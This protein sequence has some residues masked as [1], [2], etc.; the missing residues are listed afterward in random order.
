M[1][2]T[3]GTCPKTTG[4]GMHLCHDCTQ[5]LAHH[6]A[7]LTATIAELR[8]TMARQDTGTPS[9]GS[10]S[11]TPQPAINL[12]ALEAYEQLRE[13]TV[14]WAVALQGRAFYW[15][16]VTED[17]GT[18]LHQN[19]D[20]V[21][22][23]DWAPDLARELAAA[24]KQAVQ[25]TDRAADKISLGRCQTITEG[26]RC[27]DTVTAIQGHT[28]GRCRTCGTTVDVH[29]HQQWLI[30]EA[31]HVQAPLPAILRALKH[32]GHLNIP[33]TRAENW[34]ARGKLAPVRDKLYTPAAVMEAHK[35]SRAGKREAQAA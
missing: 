17:A 32:S 33:I 9:V 3:C 14:G 19:L 31:W 35:N 12:D 21:R 2:Q 15:L 27:P 20:L 5:T 10:G 6:L 22:R 30:T 28:T 8:T 13:V 29:Q 26:I 11:T 16:T 7:G 1:A 34:V 24:I 23:Q 18:Y 4:D 25:V